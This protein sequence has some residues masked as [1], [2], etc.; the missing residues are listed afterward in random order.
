M[1]HPNRRAFVAAAVGGAVLGSTSLLAQAPAAPM[2]DGKLAALLEPIRQKHDLP[3]LAAAVARSQGLVVVAAVG[4]RKRGDATAVTIHDQFHIG[5]NTKSMTGTLLGRLV[6]QGKLSWNSTLGASFPN[7]ARA[8][9]AALQAVTL[10]QLLTH[11]SGL[12]T[13]FADGRAWGE[14]AKA[15]NIRQQ[16]LAVVKKAAG[17]K[18]NPAGADYAYSNM[19]YVLAAAMAEQAMGKS[20]EDLMKQLVFE[21]LGIKSAGYGPM[22]K[23]GKVEQPWPHHA[24]GRPQPPIPQADN[25]PAMG[26]A[27]RVH[28]SLPDWA[29]YAADHLRGSRGETALLKKET[30]ARLNTSPPIGDF[31]TVGGWAGEN[32]H[33]LILAHDGSNTMNYASIVIIPADDLAVLVATNQGTVGGPG[34]KGCHDARE[35]LLETYAQA[36]R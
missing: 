34:Q 23:P 2:Q 3:A 9:P 18:L 28:C 26:P 1:S 14:F 4:A 31:Y 25:V 29:R 13:E 10:E 11:R 7:L 35:Q 32:K 20:W 19:N 16:R 22:G 5:S 15:G 24:D 6:E 12:P 33:K 27:G 21:P 30:Y 17:E 36:E 8:M